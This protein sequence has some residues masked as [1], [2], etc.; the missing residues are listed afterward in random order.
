MR[1]LGPAKP[2]LVLRDLNEDVRS[3]VSLEV[4]HLG[5]EAALPSGV[6]F[7][8]AWRFRFCLHCPL[9]FTECCLII[10]IGTAL[11]LPLQKQT[12]VECEEFAMFELSWGVDFWGF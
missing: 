2:V 4:R 10:N 6:P 8:N 7:K 1:L 11:P 5:R 3:V 9:H 12:R